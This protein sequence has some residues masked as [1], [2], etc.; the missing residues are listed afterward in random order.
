MAKEL[1]TD[2]EIKALLGSARTIAVLGAHEAAGRPATYVPEY[3]AK[4]GYRVLPVNAQLA[5]KTVLDEP[6]RASLAEL[7]TPVD[8]VDVF[9]RSEAIPAHLDDVLAMRPLPRV[10]WLQLG[11][12]NDEVARKLVEAGIDVV[13]DKCTLA[14]HKR[15]GVGRVG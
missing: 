4:V 9:R 6:V 2:A 11:I 12:R 1:T 14:E 3:L 7:G 15:L 13:Q 10:V 5:G 8:I